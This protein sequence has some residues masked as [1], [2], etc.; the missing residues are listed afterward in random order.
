MRFDLNGKAV[1]VET[2][3]DE[4]LLEVL[5]NRCGVTSVKDGCSPQGQCGCCLAVVGGKAVVTCAMKAS[6]AE[7][8]EVVTLD[9]LPESETSLIAD[10]FAAT[11][12]LQCGFCIPGLA[13]RAHHLVQKNAKPS[14]DEIA[15]AI[16]V[17]LC[18]CT[19][20]TKILDAIELYAGVKRGEATVQLETDG[21]VG[22]RLTRYQAQDLALGRRDYVADMTREGMLFGAVRLSDHPRARV[23]KI[24]TSRAEALDGVVKVATHRDVPGDRWYGLIQKDW[25]GLVAEGEE[26]RCVG[27]FLAAVAAVDEHTARK[28][29]ALIDIEYEVL[30]P[31]VEMEE[32]IKD[33]APQVNPTSAAGS[34]ILGHTKI[35]RGNVDTAF[36]SSAHVVEGQFF[37]QRIEHLFLEPE[38]GFA[39]VLEN[40]QIKLYTQGQGIFDDRRQCASFLGIPE[41][42]FQVELVPNGGAFGG[43]EDM[44]IQA[45]TALLC[46]LTQKPVRLLLSREQSVRVHPKRHPLRMDY[47]VGCDKDGK[48]TAVW[49]DM[50]GD[51]GA[52]A[53]VGA[54]V[55][56]RAAGHG[57]G[58]YR[59][60][61]VH[62]DA[63]ATYTNNPPCGAMRGFGANQAHFAMSTCLDMLA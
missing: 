6:K 31:V 18:R 49:A 37:T 44:S 16:D 22:K 25:P 41:E 54:K 56:E 38:C 46:H 48:V 2:R 23:I 8:K 28:A 17:H 21:G 36:A 45:H 30:A 1:E 39:E 32:A 3:E 42:E 10:C 60:D 13:M 62:I 63:I 51:T 57:C 61:N 40:G 50:L 43:K 33:G 24:D 20:Y 58:P 52:Y 14:R 11:A 4:S 34:N 19:G 29:A 5:R 53:S 47:K 26:A 55:L 35:R 7:G 15:K 12:G 59:C 27:D 9:G